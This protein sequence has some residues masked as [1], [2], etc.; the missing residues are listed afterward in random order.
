[1]LT[2]LFRGLTAQPARGAALFDAV[3]NVARAPHWYREGDVPDT[4]DGRFAMV[5]TVTALVMVRLEALGD[6]GTLL[7]V[8]LTERFVEVMEVE[9]RE[10]GLGDPKLGRT[11]RKLVGALS[12]RVDLWRAAQA[13]ES[14]WANAA[15]DSVAG[16]ASG[17]VHVAKALRELADRLGDR[18]LEQLADGDFA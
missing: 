10:L 17:Q 1:M 15:T 9:H 6:T 7:S 11:V 12:R 13:G 16:G 2:N 4:L 3:T 14:D 18:T 8:A 5:T